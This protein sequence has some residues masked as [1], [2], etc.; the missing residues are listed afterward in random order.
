MKIVIR[1]EKSQKNIAVKILLHKK[2]VTIIK[3]NEVETRL[4][5]LLCRK[6]HKAFDN[7]GKTARGGSNLHFKHFIISLPASIT[8]ERKR[9]GRKILRAERSQWGGNDDDT[10]SAISFKLI[11]KSNNLPLLWKR[12]VSDEFENFFSHGGVGLI[13]RGYIEIMFFSVVYD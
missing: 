2:K 7:G 9:R 10:F 8:M 3:W 13:L 5:L 12:D 6:R 11:E 1:G 4:W